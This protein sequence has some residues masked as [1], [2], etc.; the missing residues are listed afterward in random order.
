EI[1]RDSLLSTLKLCGMGFWILIGAN[2]YL[3][4][5][6]ALGAQD[7]LTDLILGMPGGTMG[8]LLMMMLIVLVLG[9]VMDDWAI[10]M[11]CTPLFLPIITEL[12]VNKIWFG[13]LFIVNIQVA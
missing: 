10:I 13:V 5:F 7:L 12:G 4:I 3:N 6:N 11:L 8:V 9:T 1:F 2:I